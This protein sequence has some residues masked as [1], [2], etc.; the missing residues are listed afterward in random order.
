MS[1]LD[2]SFVGGGANGQQGIYFLPPNPL[3]SGAPP[4]YPPAPI[5]IADLQ[6]PIPAGVGHFTS[7]A[8]IACNDAGTTLFN[9]SGANGQSGLYTFTSNVLATVVAA[10]ASLPIGAGDTSALINGVPPSPCRIKNGNVAFIATGADGFQ[11]VYLSVGTS[12]QFVNIA[13]TFTTI[14]NSTLPFH[15]FSTV[16]Y[17]GTFVAFVGSAAQITDAPAL[18]AVCKVTPAA[19]F[20]PPNP[21]LV[22]ADTTTSVPGGIG[23]FFGFGT[24]VID[25]GVVVFEG[26]SS[27]GAGGT[28]SGLYTDLGGR[29]SKIV[30][31]GDVVNGKT[32]RFLSFGPGSFDGLQ[33]AFAT[34]F[35]DGSQGIGRAGTCVPTAFTG[36]DAPIGGADATGGTATSPLRAFK[37]NSTVP[38]KMSL[39]CSGVPVTTG[40]HTVQ[41]QK[42]SNA[43]DATIPIDA[44]PTDGA[45]LG[46]VFRLDD[47]TLGT[48]HFNLSTKSLSKGVWQIRVTLAD[49]SLHTAYIELK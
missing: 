21:C 6:T 45:T 13:S 34:T 42:V 43:T 7:F 47:A 11:G 15:S 39:G 8:P 17:D 18:S 5:R 9:G 33:V 16:S 32:V 4:S 12:G 36:F 2:I 41:L 44:T 29:L 25:P 24:V 35:T 30:A 14:P 46:N 1:G 31:D 10:P 19:P 20:T 22:V 3:I 40:A 26:F 38:V 48:W 37:L 28:R 49:G 27:D 23:T